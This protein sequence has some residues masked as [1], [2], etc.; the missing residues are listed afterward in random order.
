MSFHRL[1]SLPLLAATLCLAACSQE[2]GPGTA[3][4]PAGAAAD[5]TVST[6]PAAAPA[7]ADLASTL[8]A[9]HWKIVTAVDGSGQSLARFFP[10]PAQPLG[11]DFSE[12]GA[13]VT[14]GCNRISASYEVTGP[15]QVQF[16][17]GRSTMMACPPPLGDADKA[18][19]MFLTGTLQ[20]SLADDAGTPL[21]TLAMNDGTTLTL[22]GTPTA[23]T[24]YGGPG[25]R[26]FLEVSTESCP[27][28]AT[29][30]PCI[31]VRDRSFDE[32][33][34]ESGTPGEWRALPEGIEGYTPAAGEQQVVR[35]KRFDVPADA[36]GGA[37]RTHHV[38]DMVV[39][40]RTVN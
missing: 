23:E 32:Q 9:H 34:L 40:S 36:A 39:Q 38:F 31:M 3:E 13:H 19:A 21:L 18:M 16:G 35:V 28:P 27:A 37:A 14:G 33:G 1:L 24:R 10:N 8:P 30:P 12:G 4:P 25:A 15:A 5:A 2:R 29:S 7:A 17:P 26:A 20:A 6:P 11:I 22:K